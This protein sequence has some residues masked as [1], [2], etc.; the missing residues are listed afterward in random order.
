ML[1][2]FVPGT[3]EGR[4]IAAL[5]LAPDAVMTVSRL[6]GG[7]SVATADVVLMVDENGRVTSCAQASSEAAAALVNAVCSA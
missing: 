3:R 4:S 2:M 7:Q 5:R 1:K 6:P